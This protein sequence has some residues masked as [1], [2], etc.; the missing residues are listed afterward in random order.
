[1]IVSPFGMRCSALS[2][3]ARCT[4]QVRRGPTWWRK[5]NIDP[6]P[7]ALRLWWADCE[8]ARIKNEQGRALRFLAMRLAEHL[9]PRKA[10]IGICRNIPG[11]DPVPLRL[12][13]NPTQISA[14]A[15][16]GL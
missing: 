14:P 7:V 8:L 3:T 16:C 15:S 12:L 1:M 13:E 11:L 4:A 6:L 5:L 9:L 10:R 2:A